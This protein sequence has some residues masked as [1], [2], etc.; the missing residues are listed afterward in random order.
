VSIGQS[1]ILVTLTSAKGCWDVDWDITVRRGVVMVTAPVSVAV[2]VA[3]GVTGIVGSEELSL[4]VD[5][6]GDD[7]TVG[8][9]DSIDPRVRRPVG[10]V[11]NSVVIPNSTWCRL[12]LLVTRGV[13]V[14]G[15]RDSVGTVN[16]NERCRCQKKSER[17]L[18]SAT[19]LIRPE[20]QD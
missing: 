20:R 8:G 18:C 17:V 7:G 9:F 2:A 6:V 10:R 15:R 13:G 5:G 3:E 16:N 1:F 19:S 14:E 4:L 11:S 12:V